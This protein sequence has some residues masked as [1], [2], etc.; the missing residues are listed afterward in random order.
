LVLDE[1]PIV[2]L[3]PLGEEKKEEEPAKVDLVEAPV[4]N[5]KNEAELS[6]V[7]EKSQTEESEETTRLVFILVLIFEKIKKKYSNFD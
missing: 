7:M 5:D 2:G 4:L 6:S 3:E 1:K